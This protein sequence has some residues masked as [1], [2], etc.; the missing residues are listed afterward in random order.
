M[1]KTKIKNTIINKKKLD[2]NKHKHKYSKIH[3]GGAKALVKTK[4]EEEI[5][6]IKKL[7]KDKGFEY[8]KIKDD[9]WCYYYAI[10]QGISDNPNIKNTKEDAEKLAKLIVEWFIKNEDTP[11]NFIA[12]MTLKNYIES[13]EWIINPETTSGGQETKKIK[14]NDFLKNIVKSQKSISEDTNGFENPGPL[15]WADYI[16]FSQAV[17]DINNINIKLYEKKNNEI[18]K[19]QSSIEFKPS[20]GVGSKTINLII[21]GDP[22]NHF[23]LL[24]PIIKTPSPK[25][26]ETDIQQYSSLLINNMKDVKDY[27]EMMDHTLNLPNHLLKIPFFVHYNNISYYQKIDSA[28]FKDNNNEKILQSCYFDLKENGNEERIYLIRQIILPY[29][30][31]I[32]TNTNMNFLPDPFY[33]KNNEIKE[34]FNETTWAQL[35]RIVFSGNLKLFNLKTKKIVKKDIN[36]FCHGDQFSAN[37]QNID[38]IDDLEIDKDKLG[39]NNFFYY[40][41]FT[42]D[43]DT[44]T[45]PPIE[46]MPRTKENFPIFKGFYWISYMDNIPETFDPIPDLEPNLC[47]VME[48]KFKELLPTEE[49]IKDPIKKTST[50]KSPAITTKLYS[51]KISFCYN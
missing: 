12:N 27:D 1:V 40:V 50:V 44:I 15:I 49:P 51:P 38:F 29:D 32:K 23:D 10:L 30:S 4:E 24:I 37:Q 39:D 20:V 31:S 36:V 8:I 22:Q 43:I 47:D 3:R 34:D 13:Q 5:E 9:G 25:I 11:Y 16:T 17:A 21:V 42:P 33:M 19:K 26:L 28:E 7:A 6:E 2:S 45:Y 18:L 35:S 48:K 41:E 14:F 46:N